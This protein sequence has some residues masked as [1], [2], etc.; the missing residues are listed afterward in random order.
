MIVPRL[1]FAALLAGPAPAG[2]SASAPPP[3]LAAAHTQVPPPEHA[4]S[5]QPDRVCKLE[6]VDTRIKRKV[7]YDRNQMSERALY[8][9]QRLDRMQADQH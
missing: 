7:C 1:L 4:A 5:A 6:G 3:P 9:R 2:G 8:D